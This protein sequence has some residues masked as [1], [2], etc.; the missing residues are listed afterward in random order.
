MPNLLTSTL[1]KQ[2]VLCFLYSTLQGQNMYCKSS[3]DL[4]KKLFWEN[5]AVIE[6]T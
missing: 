3:N 2:M 6:D 4:T 5:A 1:Q